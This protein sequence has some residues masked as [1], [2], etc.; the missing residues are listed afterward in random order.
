[1]ADARGDAAAM[2]ADFQYFTAPD[3]AKHIVERLGQYPRVPDLELDALRLAGRMLVV[4]LVLGQYRI[5]IGGTAPHLP[6]AAFLAN[7]ASHLDSLAFIAAAPRHIRR[8]LAV[9]AARDY[10]FTRLHRA[11]AAALVAQAVAFDR[12]H[13]LELRS[14]VRRLSEMTSG[15][16]L[17]FPSGSRRSAPP[18]AG[19]LAMLQ[20]SGWPLVPVAIGGTAEAWPPGRRLWRPFRT[21]RVTFGTPLPHLP[22][23]AIPEVVSQ[24]WQEHS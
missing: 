14:W 23:R 9:L 22:A 3:H 15:H 19:F 2:V 21:L 24:F 1:M 5:E 17:V 18:H 20:A 7:H 4:G 12:R 13:A 16:L 8:D 11:A 10:F 6:R